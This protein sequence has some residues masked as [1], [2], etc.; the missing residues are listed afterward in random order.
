MIFSTSYK[1]TPK[2]NF[3]IRNFIRTLIPSFIY[4]Y[5]F[6]QLSLLNDN[7]VKFRINYYLKLKSNFLIDN[8]NMSY[9]G[10][11]K[12]VKPSA[13]YYD[14]KQYLYYFP[15]YFKFN[16]RFGDD[17]NL[18]RFPFIVKARPIYE[19]NR[20]AV[21]LNLNKVRHFQFVDDTTPYRDKK[22]LV[23]WRGAAYQ[24]HRKMLVKKFHHH[25]KCNIGQTNNPIESVPWQKEKLTIEEQLKYK[26][27]LSV[28]GNDVAS[29]LKWT[30]SSN[31]LCLM[32]KPKYETW[33]MEGLLVSG[34]HFVELK[35]DYS[36]LDEKVDWYLMHPEEAE[37]IIGN[38]HQFIEQFQTPEIEDFISI[39]VLKRYF[40]LSGQKENI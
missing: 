37:A 30:L 34:V 14:L 17:T 6:N 28:E 1:K 27:I 9:I 20:N 18:E 29:S 31:S 39:A 8:E 12:N 7:N 25:A 32:V 22:D 13:Y 35:D 16:Y 15:T 33:F 10:E 11:F 19:D 26:F 40:E 38:A 24:P 4:Q 5:R 2:Y 3:Y 36:D 21:L 23:V